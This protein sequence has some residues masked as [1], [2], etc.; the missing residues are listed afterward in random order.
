MGSIPIVESS[1]L[2]IILKDLPVLIIKDWSCITEEY[3]KEQYEII[4]SKKYNFEKIFVQY[5][6]DL[7][8]SY[9]PH[10]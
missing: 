10:E 2:D 7:I 9:K 5:W 6:F 4:N 3:L 8:D 1:Q